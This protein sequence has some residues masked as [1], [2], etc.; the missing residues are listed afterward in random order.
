MTLSSVL[1]LPHQSAPS[2]DNKNRQE[3]VQAQMFMNS[4][5]DTKEILVLSLKSPLNSDKFQ[6]TEF[7][8][9]LFSTTSRLELS[10]CMKVILNSQRSFTIKSMASQYQISW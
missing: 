8:N 5:W 10:S 9:Q 3:S 7:T 4:F 1:K 2:K 6:K